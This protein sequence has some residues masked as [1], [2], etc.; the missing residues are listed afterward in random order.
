MLQ[1]ESLT[2]WLTG[3]RALCHQG[4]TQ[5]QQR[6]EHV[7]GPGTPHLSCDTEAILQ[8]SGCRR[9]RS[10]NTYYVLP[11]QPRWMPRKRWK[12]CIPARRGLWLFWLRTWRREPPDREEGW[13][14]L[15]E[16]GSP[17]C[18]QLLA[19]GEIA[20]VCGRQE[21]LLGGGVDFTFFS[22]SSSSLSSSSSSSII[23]F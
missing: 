19:G 9:K 18:L 14:N 11:H 4:W 16:A 10:L 13:G 7:H 23:F 2:A 21:R 1:Q 20:D 8:M 15:G 22:S 6:H 5:R 12:H 17:A 3:H